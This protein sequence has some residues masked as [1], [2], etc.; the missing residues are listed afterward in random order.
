M[1]FSIDVMALL[2][3]VAGFAGFIDAVAGGGGLI[4]IPALLATGMPPTQ[5]LATNKLQGSF[6]SF[7]SSL[8]FVRNGLVSLKEMRFAILC[9]FIGAALGAEMVQ[10]IDAS[11]LT[12]LIPGLLIGISLYFLLVPSAGK[13]GG[14]PKMSENLFALTVGTGIGF[15]DG[16]FGP[17][18]GSLFTICFVTIA[19]LAGGSDRPD[20]SA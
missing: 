4:T 7:S 1:E 17:G 2:F 18:T 12:S 9:T 5:A 6:G 15:Y 11:I 20:Q 3:L 10:L 16:F 14:K 13:G 8:Y 19:Q